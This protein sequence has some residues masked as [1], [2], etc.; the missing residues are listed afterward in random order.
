MTEPFVLME[1]GPVRDGVLADLRH[2][3]ERLRA[4]GTVP[5]LGTI[6]VGDDPAS[7]SYVRGKVSTAAKLSIRSREAH[8]PAGAGQTAVLELVAAWNED[9]AV[10]GILVQLPLPKGYDPA[11]IQEAVRPSKD[12]DGFHPSNMGALALKGFDPLFVPC[13]PAG[14]M[15]MLRHYGVEVAGA[16]AVVLG[17]SNIVGM[18]MALLLTKADATVTIAHSRTTNVASLCREADLVV[19]AIGKPRFVTSDMVRRGA[20]VVDVGINRVDGRLVG[21][22]SFDSVKTVAR[23][24]SPVPGGV[25]PLTVAMLMHN[26]VLAAER[27]TLAGR[28][29]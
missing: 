22:V 4:S 7:L 8:L 6:V 13:T 10:H 27:A 9:P 3:V 15:A 2:R 25:G 1:G 17:R 24:A 20:V 12:V 23:A 29:T 18:P 14:V 11:A 19:A 5:T 26:V 16:R 21:D 28:T